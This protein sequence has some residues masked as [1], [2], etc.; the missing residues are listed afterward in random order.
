MDTS[1][2][3]VGG[4]GTILPDALFFNLSETV[5]FPFS[6]TPFTVEGDYNKAVLR[7]AMK[8]DRLLAIFPEMQESDD[9]EELPC[10]VD[11]DL[12]MHDEIEYF[13]GGI[14]VRVVKE[15]TLPDGS[16][17][18]VVRG[19]KRIVFKE[20]VPNVKLAE[21][22]TRKVRYTVLD[23]GLG[24]TTDP[25]LLGY[26]K[27]I[28][29][30]FQEYAAM[31]PAMPEEVSLGAV[32]APNVLRLSDMVA[33]ALSLNIT[34][35]RIFLAVP[36]LKK[37]CE[38]L[39]GWLNRELIALRLG[40]K[41]QNE[42]QINLGESQRE[43]YLREQLRVIKNELGED[44]RNP[45][46][47][48]LDQKF[49][50]QELPPEVAAVVQ[51]ELGR[52]EL[53]PQASPEYNI[54]YTYLNWLLDIPWCIYTE[55]RLDF[56]AA[57]EVLEA[58][59]YGLEDVKKRILEFL[60]VLQLKQNDPD[61]RAPILCLVGPPGVGKTSIGKSIARAM[62]RKFIRVSLGGVRDE[63]EIR[64]HRKTYVGAMPGRIM[65][66]LKR[67]GS[68]N[69]VFMLDEVDKLARDNHGD[70][71]AALLE[72]LDPAQNNS[73]NDNYIEIGYDLSR[74]FFIATANMLEG[75]P[76]PLLDRMEVIRIPGYTSLEKRE[77]AKR[78]LIPRQIKENGLL[79]SKVKF[80]QGA[81]D[82][83]IT[84]YTMESGVRELERVF[85]RVCRRLAQKLVTGEIAHD[86]VVRVSAKMIKELLG[87]RKYLQDSAIECLM[88]GYAVGMAWT[89]AGGTI[90][91]IEIT[92]IPGGKGNL[93]L[94]GSLGKVM[95]ESA[96]TAFSL[97]RSIASEWNVDP[98]YF[99]TTDFHIHVPDGATPKDGPSA[100]VTMTMALLS[101]IRKKCLKSYVSMTG[102]VTLHGRVTAIGGLREK[103]VAAL[104]AGIREVILPEE[105]RKDFE[106]LPEQVREKLEFHFV[107]DFREAVKAAFPAE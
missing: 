79:V 11:L 92:A 32:N 56:A 35:K 59:H 16:V 21:S 28:Q 15:L 23:D 20:F 80:N 14:L 17:R 39:A 81:I 9:W 34:E 87:P 93:K 107:K 91:P 19:L 5:V 72:V 42:V 62:E 10:S 6:L 58:D 8:T 98:E 46:I 74:V 66:N 48:E 4:M 88:P 44:T 36:S 102:E 75:I 69:P 24:A 2:I 25:E 65:Q 18:V 60:A 47:I 84:F 27:S 103:C 104:R 97:V 71:A 101:L 90:L 64:G 52:L 38:L 45:D 83:I 95:Q 94:T 49:Q 13:R 40:M 31:S 77:I 29:A 7:E 82:E 3:S 43:F 50:A 22:I 105:N 78:Y 70:P 51:K 100:G 85:A 57:A 26:F 63:A 67:A 106:E 89:A 37:R 30:M 61:S 99:N 73:F 53:I 33:E 12:F 68:S 55:D 54:S 86:E 1:T 41:I 76:G 96:E